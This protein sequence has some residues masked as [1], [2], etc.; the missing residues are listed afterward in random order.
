MYVLFFFAKDEFRC[1]SGECVSKVAQCDGMSDC[2]D[3]S[4]ESSCNAFT[5]KTN[6]F[7]CNTGNCIPSSWEC[8]SQIDCSDGS[9]E[10]SKCCK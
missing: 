8:D 10:G 2:S 4:D 9:D 5:C 3:G 6:E 1:T 7:R